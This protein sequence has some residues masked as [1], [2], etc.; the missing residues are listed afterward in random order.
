MIPYPRRPGWNVKGR[1]WGIGKGSELRAAKLGLRTPYAQS[2]QQR[3][4][5]ISCPAV[6]S[7]GKKITGTKR[8]RLRSGVGNMKVNT[9]TQSL[10]RHSM[11]GS[12]LFS[13]PPSRFNW[14]RMSLKQSPGFLKR[15]VLSWGATCPTVSVI[16]EKLGL[17]RCNLSLFP[18]FFHPSSAQR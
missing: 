15:V 5:L 18:L 8:P 1:V 6:L 17:C 16:G 14:N 2:Q 7:R 11:S 3:L 4:Y 9:Q 12:Q 10:G 13:G